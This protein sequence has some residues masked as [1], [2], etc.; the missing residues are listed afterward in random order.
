MKYYLYLYNYAC[1][2]VYVMKCRQ[3]LLWMMDFEVGH[4]WLEVVVDYFVVLLIICMETL[5]KAIK[6]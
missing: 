5:R 4:V 6:R 1:L 2:I 3:R